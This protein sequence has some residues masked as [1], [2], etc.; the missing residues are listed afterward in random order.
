MKSSF[1]LVSSLAIFALAIGCNASDCGNIRDEAVQQ[2]CEQG[3]TYQQENNGGCPGCDMNKVN[4]YL[5]AIKT[6]NCGNWVGQGNIEC[7]RLHQEYATLG[8]N[9]N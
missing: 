7:A 1:L 9:W 3:C 4:E 2:V 8:C 6:G 5:S